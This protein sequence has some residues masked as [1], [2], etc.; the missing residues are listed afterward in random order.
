[1]TVQG[2]H[3]IKGQNEEWCDHNLE[4]EMKLEEYGVAY[5][6]K[7]DLCGLLVHCLGCRNGFNYNSKPYMAPRFYDR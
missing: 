4:D 3:H 6:Y 2:Q 5:C 7:C 1:M